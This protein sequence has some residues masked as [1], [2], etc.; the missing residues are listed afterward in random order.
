[1]EN[2]SAQNQSESII[3]W[4]SQ[5]PVVIDTI[6][7]TG[8]THVKK[9][10]IQAKYGDAAW[11]FETAYAFFRQGAEAKV[12]RPKEA[13]SAIWAYRRQAYSYPSPGFYSLMLEVPRDQCVLFDLRVWN[14]ILSLRYVGDSRQDERAFDKELERQGIKNP[15]EIFSTPFYPLLRRR[16]TDSWQKLFTS[17]ETCEEDYLQA[18]LWEIRAEW[19]K[20]CVLVEEL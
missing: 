11:S 13:E 5:A 6:R 3:L 12:A 20:Q 7:R 19:I 1:M 9:E 8:T 15:A 2:S 14:K 16:V 17:A 4:A 10:F 18:G